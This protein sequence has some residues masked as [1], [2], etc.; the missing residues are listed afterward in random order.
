M[1]ICIRN[2]ATVYVV[3]IAS[4]FIPPTSTTTHTETLEY[5]THSTATKI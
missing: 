2:F 4:T 3:H 5:F 1:C